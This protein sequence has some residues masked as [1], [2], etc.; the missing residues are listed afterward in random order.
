VIPVLV[1]TA[2]RTAARAIRWTVILSRGIRDVATACP[3]L[4]PRDYTQRPDG[5]P[6]TKQERP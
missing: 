3:S 5:R 6:T 1:R 4:D 2:G